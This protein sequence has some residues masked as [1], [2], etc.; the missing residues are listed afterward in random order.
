MKLASNEELS[1]KIIETLVVLLTQYSKLPNEYDDILEQVLSYMIKNDESIN[2]H[3][4]YKRYLKLLYKTEKFNEL[5]VEAEK[6]HKIFNQDIYP[7]G[8]FEFFSIH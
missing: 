1:K 2:R 6:M 8:I 7:L 4:Y 3:E 5:F